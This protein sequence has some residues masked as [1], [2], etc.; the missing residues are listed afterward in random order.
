MLTGN[1]AQAS[2]AFDDLRITHDAQTVREIDE[3][4]RGIHADKASL[5]EADAFCA[6]LDSHHAWNKCFNGYVN[7]AGYGYV[8]EPTFAVTIDGWD[9]HAAFRALGAT[10]R[11]LV[12]VRSFQSG[13]DIDRESG[14]N[15]LKHECGL[16]IHDNSPF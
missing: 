15:Y 1:T 11:L 16:I 2:L 13:H 14:R 8:Y 5:A 4:A 12:V 9:A 10:A 7:A 3:I 6:M